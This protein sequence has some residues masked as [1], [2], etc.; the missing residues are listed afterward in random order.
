MGEGDCR[1]EDS[2]EHRVRPQGWVVEMQAAAAAGACQCRVGHVRRQE[3][4][5]R[6]LVGAEQRRQ[7]GS[8]VAGRRQRIDPKWFL[9]RRH[10]AQQPDRRRRTS[11]GHA[12][13]PLQRISRPATRPGRGPKSQPAADRALGPTARRR[14]RRRRPAG[15]RPPHGGNRHEKR[16]LRTAAVEGCRPRTAPSDARP[17]RDRAGLRRHWRPGSAGRPRRG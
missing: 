9:V 5:H 1:V 11:T 8:P 16:P 14:G 6:H 10:R 4:R 3:D 13:G 17:V 7:A 12:R 15:R 2:D